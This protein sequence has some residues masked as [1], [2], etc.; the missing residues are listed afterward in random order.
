M[1]SAESAAELDAVAAGCEAWKF[2]SAA[3]KYRDCDR[4]A[5]EAAER[6]GCALME[7]GV[8]ASAAALEADDRG[9][10]AG[11]ARYG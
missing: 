5:E 3:L 6:D 2:R 10:F 7:A 4:G 9:A 8:G 1:G 11:C